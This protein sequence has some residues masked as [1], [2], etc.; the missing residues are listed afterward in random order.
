MMQSRIELCASACVAPSHCC[1]LSSRACSRTAANAHE[2]VTEE[3]GRKNTTHNRYRGPER[4]SCL[5]ALST[6]THDS[7]ALLSS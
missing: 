3:Q 1:A 2:L 4:L 5:R 7:N 6:L